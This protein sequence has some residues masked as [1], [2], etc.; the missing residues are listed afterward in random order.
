MKLIKIAI[1][2]VYI[3]YILITTPNLKCCLSTSNEKRR[4]FFGVNWAFSVILPHI[5]YFVLMAW[6]FCH[7]L[8]LRYMFVSLTQSVCKTHTKIKSF[9]R[10]SALLLI[11]RYVCLCNWSVY[12]RHFRYPYG[13]RYICL[14]LWFLSECLMKTLLISI[15]SGEWVY[16]A[17]TPP[18]T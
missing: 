8:M 14:Y 10:V 17:F 7:L 3:Y 18:Q 4:N 9:F 16:I 6:F 5:L 11:L 1:I 12:E 2:R 15:W 13:V